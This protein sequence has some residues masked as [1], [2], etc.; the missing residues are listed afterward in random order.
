MSRLLRFLT[1]FTLVLFTA[2]SAYAAG[3]TCPSS[4]KYTSCAAGYYMTVNGTYNGTPTAGNA[5]TACGTGYTCAGGTANRVAA[6]KS[7]SAGQYWNGSA[8]A[9]CTAGYYCP[10]FSNVS[11]PA[12]NYGRN[13]CAAGT[14]SGAGA[15]GCTACS[16]ALQY[17]DATAQTSCKSVSTGYYKSSNS[18][19]AACPSG[20]GNIAATS[21]AE[22]VGTFSKSGSQTDPA[23]PTGCADRSLTACTPGT[24]SYTK[25]YSGTVVSDCTPTNCTKGQSCTSASANYYLDAGTA[26]TCSS[27]S[28]TYTLS[29]GGNISSAN[30]YKMS[31]KYGNQVPGDRPMACASVTEW[32]A[33]T[34]GSCQYKDYYSATDGTCTATDCTQTPKSVT[35]DSGAYVLASGVECGYCNSLADGFYPNSEQGNTGGASAC[36]SNTLNGSY[37]ATA[38]AT[39]TTPCPA[40]TFAANVTV[41][42]GS[43]SE[44]E[45]CPDNTWSDAGADMCNACS[46]GFKTL[47]GV[48]A[49]VKSCKIQCPGGTYLASEYANTCTDVGFGYW[50]APSVVSQGD[51]GVR[52][53]CPNGWMTHGFGEGADELGDCGRIMR[54]NG[55]EM[56]LRSEKKTPRSLVFS[57]GDQTFYGNMSTEVSTGFKIRLDG[58]DYSVYDDGF[59]QL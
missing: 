2:N 43:T 59:S 53:Q 15:S 17:Q 10:G 55:R 23:I 49:G 33:C 3:Y 48:H 51:V 19:Q 16:G 38:G 31:T 58:V 37:I 8:C 12:T 34:P 18:A 45:T 1:L 7:C 26:K 52:N 54:V 42:Y 28:S 46:Y 32:N 50:A 21:Q 5:C 40:G 22:C 27:F 41:S 57:I 39:G 36:Y 56:I 25:K 11:N 24:C 47:D 20:Y 6:T 14:Y 35:A 44:C 29:D 30:C 9:S 4:K 13:A